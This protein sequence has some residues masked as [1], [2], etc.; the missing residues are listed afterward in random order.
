MWILGL[1]GLTGQSWCILK[2]LYTGEEGRPRARI[3][4]LIADA[5]NQSLVSSAAQAT[6]LFGGAHY[7]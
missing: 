7:K 1:K 2:S 5:L 3:W 6:L 4:G